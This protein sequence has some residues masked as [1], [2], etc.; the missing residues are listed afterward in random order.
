MALIYKAFTRH[1]WWKLLK[2]SLKNSWNFASYHQQKIDIVWLLIGRTIHNLNLL[3]KELKFSFLTCTVLSR[4][5]PLPTV[6]LTRACDTCRCLNKA[7]YS[8]SAAFS[9]PRWV[10]SFELILNNKELFIVYILDSR[11]VKI[12]LNKTAKKNNPLNLLCRNTLL[13]IVR[14][15]RIN[16]CNYSSFYYLFGHWKLAQW[17][18]KCEIYCL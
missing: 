9:I 17:T 7:G 10:G 18:R 12:V 2:Q 14:S 16:Y 13:L 8:A 4:L 15:G 6:G 1:P 11:A 3:T 5:G